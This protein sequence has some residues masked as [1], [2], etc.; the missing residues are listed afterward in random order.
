[1]FWSCTDSINNNQRLP[2]GIWVNEDLT[3]DT[4]YTGGF[5]FIH[6]SGTL[7]FFD[8]NHTIKSFSNTFINNNDSI[9]WGEPGIIL[10]TEKWRKVGSSI[11]ATSKIIKRTF[12]IGDDTIGRIKTAR[13]E[14]RGD[15]L[16]RNKSERFLP[17]RLL[18][19]ELNTFLKHDWSSIE[20]QSGR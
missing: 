19:K 13:F 8:T 20:K 4:V 18:S 6:G 7:I 14:L 17:A 12:V 15:T 10:T 11:I 2:H 16:I 3:F 9:A 1:M 5:H